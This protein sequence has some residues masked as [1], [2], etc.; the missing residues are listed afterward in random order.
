MSWFQ[1]DSCLVL[2]R[3]EW[4][5]RSVPDKCPSVTETAP[6][7]TWARFREGVQ[8]NSVAVT[9]ATYLLGNSFSCSHGEA[10]VPDEPVDPEEETMVRPRVHAFSL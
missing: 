10:C 1:T 2:C 5:T 3:D 9:R 6:S 8:R 4:R 7:D